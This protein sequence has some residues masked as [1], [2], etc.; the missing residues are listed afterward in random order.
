MNPIDFCFNW[1]PFFYSIKAFSF[2][3]LYWIRFNKLFMDIHSN[4]KSTSNSSR[5]RFVDLFTESEEDQCQTYQLILWLYQ[6]LDVE[7]KGTQF[8]RLNYFFISE[9][10]FLRLGFSYHIF[11][12]SYSGRIRTSTFLETLFGVYYQ[13]SHTHVQ[14]ACKLNWTS[15]DQLPSL[16]GLRAKHQNA[17]CW[18]KIEHICVR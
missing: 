12:A 4:Q 8:T 10:L 6:C 9:N 2:H 17:L 14:N 16:H 15:D 11:S 1:R 5:R 7:N 3:S 13:A 18:M